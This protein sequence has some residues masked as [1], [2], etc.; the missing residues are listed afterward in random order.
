MSKVRFYDVD[1]KER[2]RVIGEL[3]D[4]LAELK[5]KDEVVRFLFGLFTPSEVLM[6]GRRIQIAKMLIEGLSYIDIGKNLGVSHQTVRK[7]EYWLKSDDSRLKFI[8]SKISK[9]K[10]KKDGKSKNYE[11][12]LDRYP[13]HRMAKEL[14]GL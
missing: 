4:V 10:T 7:V 14:F 2:Y 12:L 5:T 3:Y 11:S 9:I 8:S 6:I 1:K 13:E